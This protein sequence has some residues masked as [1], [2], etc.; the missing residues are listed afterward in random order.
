MAVADPIA[1]T[2]HTQIRRSVR[3][4]EVVRLCARVVKRASEGSYGEMDCFVADR[5]LLH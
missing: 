2:S 5:R 4:V 3:P 1:H